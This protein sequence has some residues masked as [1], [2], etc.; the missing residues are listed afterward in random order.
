MHLAR[1]EVEVG[2]LSQEDADIAVP[3]E[4]RMEGIGDL[5]G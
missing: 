4:D 2:D 1:L 5:T 3:L